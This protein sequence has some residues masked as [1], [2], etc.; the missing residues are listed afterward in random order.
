[1]KNHCLIKIITL[2][3]A[4]ELSSVQMTLFSSG[5]CCDPGGCGGGSISLVELLLGDLRSHKRPIMKIR[6]WKPAAA[7]R[8]LPAAE[9]LR[10][11]IK[12]QRCSAHFSKVFEDNICFYSAQCWT[13]GHWERPS[14]MMVI[15]G[16]FLQLEDED[17]AAGKQKGLQFT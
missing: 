3:R 17:S 2:T 1:M 15:T 4:K 5:R 10:L 11:L 12:L 7:C 8:P 13:V 6:S 9:A 14:I 16:E